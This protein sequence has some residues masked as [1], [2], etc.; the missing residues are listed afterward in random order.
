MQSGD[1]AS[2]PSKGCPT[3]HIEKPSSLPSSLPQIPRAAEAGAGT[4]Q[5][6]RVPPLWL[7][8]KR[9][10]LGGKNN[11][12]DDDEEEEDTK[13]KNKKTKK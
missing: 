8:T 12:K 2:D 1:W 7:R 13:R 10:D 11:N 5:R 9:K 4:A 6:L 3:P